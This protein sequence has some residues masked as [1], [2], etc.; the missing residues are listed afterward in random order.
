VRVHLRHEDYLVVLDGSLLVGLRDLRRSSPT[1]DTVALVE[2]RGSDLSAMTIPPG[3]AHG[4]YS[5]EPAIFVLGV[6]H[7]YDLTDEIACSWDD[8][9]LGIP[10]PFTSARVSPGDAGGLRLSE[11]A[12][13]VSRSV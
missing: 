11:V 13:I 6:T 1:R 5:P 4:L 7:Y 9:G 10:W 8:P 3:V 2:M 12:E